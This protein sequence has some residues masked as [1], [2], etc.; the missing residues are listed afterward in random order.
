MSS[1]AVHPEDDPL[2]TRP[3]PPALARMFVG[4]ALAGIGGG[5]PAHTRRALTTRGWMTEELFAETFT[6]AQLTPGPNAVNLAAMVGA[7]LAG[8]LGA[9]ASVLGVLTP[10]LL[11]MLA[12][13]VVTLGQPGGLPPSLQS[14]LRG[15]A[16][17]ALAVLLTAALPVVRVGWGVRG[18]AVITMLAFLALGVLRLDLL[19]VLL[20]LLGAGLLIHRP[21]RSDA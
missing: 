2:A 16:C 17:A 9:V 8:R 12:V 15:A 14:A 11:A 1:P 3:T 18:G 20:V 19:P 5:L 13:S 7:R 6:L 21:R 4:V 10:G